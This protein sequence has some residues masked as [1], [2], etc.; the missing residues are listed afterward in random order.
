MKAKLVKSKTAESKDF[1]KIV[2]DFRY[3]DGQTVK[4]CPLHGPC[5]M[6]YD[7]D[8]ALGSL[9]MELICSYA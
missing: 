1:F 4:K 2:L 5:K 7:Q 8:K 3:L 6:V 9:F